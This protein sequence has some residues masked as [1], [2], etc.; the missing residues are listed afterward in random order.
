LIKGAGKGSKAVEKARNATQKHIELLGQHTASFDSTGGKIG[1]G[2]DPYV[3]SRGVMHRLNKQ[4]LEENSNRQDL[5]AVQNNFASF[6]AHVIKVVQEGL[7]QF[8]TVISKQ[9]DISK[10]LYGDMVGTAQRVPADF[11][12]NGFVKRNGA[13]LIDPQA[14]ERNINSVSFPNQLHRATIPLISGSLERRTKLLRRYETNYYVITPAKY[15]HE[16][17][18]DDDFAKDPIP[19]VSLFLPDCVVGA[20]DGDKFAIKGKDTSKS[21]IGVSM[22][23]T[24]DYNFKAHTSADATKW[25]EIIRQ[26]AGQVTNDKPD[27]STPSSPASQATAEGE[28]FGTLPPRRATNGSEAVGQESGTTAAATTSLADEKAML[29]AEHAERAHAAGEHP[30]LASSSPAAAAAPATSAPVRSAP[31]PSA[32]APTAA[33][34]PPAASSHPAPTSAGPGETTAKS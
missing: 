27:V 20:V 32:P 34:A 17:K 14:P 19:D 22:H 16:F 26:A 6:E 25:W 4:I 33:A 1:S 10:S 3:L 13:V 15:L 2:D 28:K 23:T 21:K 24:H 11:E 29:A 8:N 5:I 12:W 7:G 31:A 9:A 18:T 30:A